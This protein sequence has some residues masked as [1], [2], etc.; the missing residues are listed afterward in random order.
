MVFYFFMFCDVL[1]TFYGFLLFYVLWRL[2]LC[3]TYVLELLHFVVWTLCDAT[4]SNRYVK[5]H[6]C[7]VMLMLRFVA[8]PYMEKTRF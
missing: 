3:D 1:I 7:C 8:V 5:W 6:E 2:M 4:L